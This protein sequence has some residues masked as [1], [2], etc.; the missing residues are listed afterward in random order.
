MLDRALDLEGRLSAAG[1]SVDDKAIAAAV[2]AQLAA[3]KAATTQSDARKA[4]PKPEPKK[5]PKWEPDPNS[6][7]GQQL[8]KREKARADA[9]KAKADAAAAKEAGR[10]TAEEQAAAVLKGGNRK[11]I[12]EF[13]QSDAFGD[14]SPATKAKI[15]A[16]VLGR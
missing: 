12:Y 4:E 3:S 14:L 15:F 7:A 11:A 5:E 8:A 9:E 13:Q 1:Q 2:A 16:A 6:P 10:A